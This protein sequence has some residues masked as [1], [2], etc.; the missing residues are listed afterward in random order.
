MS[1]LYGGSAVKYIRA[2]APDSY[3]SAASTT[4]SNL[5]DFAWGTLVVTAGSIAGTLNC[6][7]QRSAT[8]NGTF[9][10][11]GASVTAFAEGDAGSLKVRSFKMD[12]SA[13]F[14]KVTHLPSAAAEYAAVVIAS[15]ARQVPVNQE[16]DVTI[17]SDVL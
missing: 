7:M 11:F 10:E 3:S 8:S 2:I 13:V 16:D 15:G 12:S 1:H 6:H 14:Y 9:A 17:H 5:S 4:A